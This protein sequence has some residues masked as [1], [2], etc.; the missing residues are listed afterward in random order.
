MGAIAS[1]GLRVINEDVLRATGVAERDIEQ[2]VARE[3]REIE[4]RERAYRSGQPA[5][6][7]ADRTVILIDDG[8]ATGA[9]MKAAARALR[10]Q[11]PAELVIAVPVAARETCKA[12]RHEVDDIVCLATPEP[13]QAVGLWY[14]DFSQTTDDEVRS[15]LARNRRDARAQR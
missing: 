3:I 5:L 7:A 2:A 8:L 15:L 1:G 13:F 4:R 9:T 10:A 11:G 14:E 6:D 12:L